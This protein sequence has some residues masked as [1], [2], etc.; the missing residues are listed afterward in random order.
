MGS[1]SGFEGTEYHGRAVA[2]EPSAAGHDVTYLGGGAEDEQ[3][4]VGAD[5]H[6]T[7][8]RQAEH[9]GYVAGEEGKGLLQGG[10]RASAAS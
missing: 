4:G 5:V 2:N 8:G 10:P 3:V 6:V 1:G 9:G 7:F